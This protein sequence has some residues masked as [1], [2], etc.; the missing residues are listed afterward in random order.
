MEYIVSRRITG[1]ALVSL[2]LGLASVIPGLQV[3]GL[4]ALLLGFQAVRGMNQVQAGATWRWA[5]FLGMAL[6]AIT[7]VVL[8]IGLIGLILATLREKSHRI[9]CQNNLRRLG[10]AVLLYQD[11]REV[12]PAATL[13]QP[14]LPLEKRMSWMVGILP[15]MSPSGRAPADS[16]RL[17]QALK[18]YDEIDKTKAWDDSVNLDLWGHYKGPYLCPSRPE[19][20]GAERLLTN[21]VGIT[22]I[23]KNSAVVPVKDPDAGFFGYDRI[24]KPAIITRGTSSTYMVTETLNDNGP[25]MAG[26]RPTLRSIDPHDQPF[27]GLDRPFGGLHPGGLNVLF[28]DGS[29]RFTQQSIQPEVWIN[30]ARINDE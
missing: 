10:E 16:P 17:H 1:L 23:G 9:E 14:S 7:S 24:I 5:A 20:E 3:L 25:W 21:Y 11:E 13:S 19:S 30:Q 29:V 26:G 28:V 12:Y 27:I 22:G 2:V 8:V 15:Y 6:G 4:I 18:L